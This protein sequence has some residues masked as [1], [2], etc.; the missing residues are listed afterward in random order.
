M[1]TMKIPSDPR[2][3]ALEC[4]PLVTSAM[5]AVCIGEFSVGL[6]QTCMCCGDDDDQAPCE[7]C[8]GEGSYIQRVTVP[9]TTM[10]DIYK[11]MAAV[12]AKEVEQ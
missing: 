11:R 9:W 6:D 8:S 7:V 12:A 4:K 1:S 2:Y 10:E 3:P 5:K